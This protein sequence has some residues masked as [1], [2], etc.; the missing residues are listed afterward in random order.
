MN[1]TLKA[2]G[3][4]HVFRNGTSDEKLDEDGRGRRLRSLIIVCL[5]ILLY[6]TLISVSL[7]S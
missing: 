4:T 5:N 1:G 7:F 2:S 3:F 6:V